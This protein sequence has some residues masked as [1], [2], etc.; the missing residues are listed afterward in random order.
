MCQERTGDPT[1]N[2]AAV[3]AH[4]KHLYTNV[5]EDSSTNTIHVNIAKKKKKK[6][7]WFPLYLL[8]FSKNVLN[9]YSLREHLRMG[10]IYEHEFTYKKKMQLRY[11]KRPQMNLHLM[12]C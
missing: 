7:H 1:S 6:K 5:E 3:E 4:N 12:K 2:R 9:D 8:H 11:W 10:Q